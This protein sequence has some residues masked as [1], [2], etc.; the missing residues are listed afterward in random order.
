MKLEHTYRTLLAL[1]LLPLAPLSA[2][3]TLAAESLPPLTSTM[4]ARFKY[5]SPIQRGDTT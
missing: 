3:A 2:H 5:L 1:V 4:S